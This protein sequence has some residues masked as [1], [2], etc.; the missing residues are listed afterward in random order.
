MQVHRTFFADKLLSGGAEVVVEF[1]RLVVVHPPELDTVLVV[2]PVV[3]LVR[4]PYK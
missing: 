1:P 3:R 2:L 4:P